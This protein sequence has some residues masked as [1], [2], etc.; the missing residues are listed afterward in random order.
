MSRKVHLVFETYE[1][2]HTIWA[3]STQAKAKA[4]ASQLTVEYVEET[5]GKH[6]DEA[7][8]ALSLH[9]GKEHSE[10]LSLFP[11]YLMD[12]HCNVELMLDKEV[13]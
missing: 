3:F 2:G 8:T 6:S 1:T 5:Y 9:V 10:L 4:F 12:D 7:H 13:L 11:V